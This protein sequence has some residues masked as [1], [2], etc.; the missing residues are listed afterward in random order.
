MS[1]MCRMT[2][3][4]WV[5]GNTV[6]VYSGLC[7]LEVFIGMYDIGVHGGVVVKYRKYWPSGIHGN[8]INAY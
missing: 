8:Q 6:I 4:F 2:K 7:V 1:L 5:T 3:P